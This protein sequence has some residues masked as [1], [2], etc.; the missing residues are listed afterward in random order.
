M[1]TRTTLDEPANA[2][3]GQSQDLRDL[4]ANHPFFK[5]LRWDH[6]LALADC[7]MKTEFRAGELIFREGDPANRF[8][9]ILKGKVAL[10]ARVKGSGSVLVERIGAGEV[11]GWSWMIEPY[12]WHFDARAV[13]P[14][15][16]IFFYGTWMRELYEED[17]SLGYEMMR[18][19]AAIMLQRLQAARRRLLEKH[20]T[21]PQT[22]IGTTLKTG[23]QGPI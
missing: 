10:E 18:R 22:L 1:K 21:E 5:E 11:L 4:I 13:E 15:E 23:N 20:A 2:T 12:A 7:A 9:L 3:H 14:I 19:V 16:A 17:G 8:F 6:I